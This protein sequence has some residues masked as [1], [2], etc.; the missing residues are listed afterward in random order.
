MTVQTSS[1]HL[2]NTT[3]TPSPI[4]R[5]TRLMAIGLTQSNDPILT[6]FQN[7]VT[8]RL[9]S[10]FVVTL[11]P[12]DALYCKA[13]SCDCMSSVRLSVMLVDYDHIGWKSWKLIAR[14]ISP[15]PSLFAAQRS[16]T[17]S[18]GNMGKF[19][20]ENVRS[21]LTSITSGWI[22][23]TESHVILG[24]LLLSA[25]RVVIFAIAQLSCY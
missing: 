21:T 10:E 13:R 17:Y 23:S 11:L 15:T 20:G 24:Y 12:C 14:A 18:Q 5:E 2:R 22:Q 3:P 6:N 7:F 9:V 8:S 16:S 1:S 19:W 4:K 25:H